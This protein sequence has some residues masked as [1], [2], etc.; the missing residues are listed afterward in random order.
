M[1]RF[2]L[3]EYIEHELVSRDLVKDPIVTIQFLNF[4]VSVLGEVNRPG[5]FEITS[6]CLISV[7]ISLKDIAFFKFTVLR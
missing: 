4:K 7:N 2:E 6:D 1:T 3:G 5:T